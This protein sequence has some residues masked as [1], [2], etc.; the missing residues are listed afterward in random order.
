MAAQKEANGRTIQVAESALRELHFEVLDLH[1]EALKF[2][3]KEMR[4]C[5]KM[6]KAK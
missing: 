4:K 5:Q 3:A 1:I 6:K 2:V